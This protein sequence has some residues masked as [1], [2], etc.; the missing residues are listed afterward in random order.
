MPIFLATTALA[1]ALLAA[2]SLW[3]EEEQ[4]SI[5]R[6]PIGLAGDIEGE[7]LGFG[8]EML[9][10]V[11]VSRHSLEWVL[12][13]E[14]E[15]DPALAQGRIW[16]YILV[17]EGFSQALYRGEPM[18]M[19][20]KA[21]GGV[22]SQVL[23]ESLLEDVSGLLGASL[24]AVQALW[25]GERVYGWDVEAGEADALFLSL[26][27]RI[28]HREDFFAHIQS[29]NP[30]GINLTK[31][32]LSA[33]YVWIFLLF[34]LHL[35]AF[36][37]KADHGQ[38]RMLSG[39]GL[40]AAA[41]LAAEALVLWLGSLLCMLGTALAMEYFWPSTG[42]VLWKA[43]L[44]PSLMWILCLLAWQNGHFSP[45]DGYLQALFLLL[46]AGYMGGLFLP[47]EWLP[48]WMGLWGRRLPPGLLLAGVQQALASSSADSWLLWIWGLAAALAAY[49]LRKSRMARA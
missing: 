2:G 22:L 14:E 5:S 36:W 45:L 1:A 18:P 47:V 9:S 24:Q 39:A 17:P 3:Q 13:E 12:L 42:L 8:L 37:T 23:T 30:M 15:L 7:Y 49:A 19:Y 48:Q 40:G 26:M 46:A 28:L 33:A 32:Y 41:Q 20:Y 43:S 4:E 16:A 29:V 34:S 27:E 11:D 6:L 35:S 44:G 25:E 10:R 31:Y 21:G 38:E